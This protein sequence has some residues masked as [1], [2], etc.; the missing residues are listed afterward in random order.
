MK[1]R[2]HE[3]KGAWHS[4]VTM[5]LWPSIYRTLGWIFCKSYVLGFSRETELAGGVYKIGNSLCGYGGW[6]VP[7]LAVC[8]L[9]TQ[10]SWWYYSAWV[11]RPG[12]Q[13]SLWCF[14]QSDAGGLRTRLGCG[15]RDVDLSPRV[16]RPRTQELWS[17]RS[18]EDGHPSSRSESKESS[19][20]H[21]FGGFCSSCQRIGWC[22]LKQVREHFT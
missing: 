12:N 22:L 21:L 19:F 5:Q 1:R 7:Q 3:G 13:R 10:E 4:W 17:S 8:K 2:T 9:Y 11:Q 18:G 20:F 14:F 6:E 16:Q 15:Q